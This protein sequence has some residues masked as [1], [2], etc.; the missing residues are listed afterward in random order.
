MKHLLIGHIWFIELKRMKN[1][2]TPPNPPNHCDRTYTSMKE[3]LSMDA[4]LVCRLNLKSQDLRSL[5]SGLST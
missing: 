3:A 1:Q 5:P 2:F 4:K